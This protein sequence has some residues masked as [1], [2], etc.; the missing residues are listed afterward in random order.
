M[1]VF[2]PLPVAA[3]SDE[4]TWND[5]WNGLTSSF[6]LPFEEWTE[7]NQ[8]KTISEHL[9]S[10]WDADVGMSVVKGNNG[11]F[12]I[13]S[14]G[15]KF[16]PLGY[17]FAEAAFFR[18]LDKD[19][20]DSWDP[21]FVYSFGYED[22][23][24]YTL[25]LVY[26]NY[27]GNHSYTDIAEKY[28]KGT[29]TLKWNTPIPALLAK[30]FLIEPDRTISSSLAALY[31]PTYTDESGETGQDQ[32]RLKLTFSAPVYGEWYLSFSI[33][34]YLDSS[35]QQPWDPDYTF[36]F[37]WRGEMFSVA[38]KNYSGTRFPWRDDYPHDGGFAEGSLGITWKWNWIK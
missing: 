19:E 28:N 7:D 33:L 31:S 13:L 9:F 23:H 17:W 16:V 2:F 35:Q 32:W 14:A 21:D 26:S 1:R 8:H 37:G 4:E 5:I 18:Y 30:P 10:Q 27:A 29:Y 22:W 11:Y 3:A 24:P 34:H 12:P 38:Y 6:A 15:M 36:E 20:Q 25:S